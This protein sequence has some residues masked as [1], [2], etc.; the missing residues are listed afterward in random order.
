A[1]EQS[2]LRLAAGLGCSAVPL[3]CRELASGDEGRARWAYS[4]LAHLAGRG[5]VRDRV[6][7]ALLAAA[8]DVEA[9]DPAKTRALALPTGL[10]APA[11]GL[12]RQ[13]RRRGPGR[14]PAV[15]SARR[16][17]AGR[18]RRLAHRA[19]AEAID[20]AHRRALAARRP[21]RAHPD[22]PAP[23]PGPAGRSPPGAA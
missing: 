21:R 10:A 9:P 5:E 1:F 3:C 2:M 16:G 23:G 4:L 20:A 14:R 6:V 22:R 12:P 17:R 11:R 19:R 13:R 7:A 8:D 15:R 18:V